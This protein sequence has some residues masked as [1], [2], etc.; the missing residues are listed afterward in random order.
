[1]KQMAE[2]GRATAWLLAIGVTLR[3][4]SGLVALYLDARI[5][6]YMVLA[7]DGCVALAVVQTVL[8][9]ADRRVRLGSSPKWFI[10]LTL[11]FLLG[12]LNP[13]VWGTRASLYGS[14]AILISALVLYA[15]S[16]T[17]FG[18]RPIRILF[19]TV[20]VNSMINALFALR[21][22][23]MGLSDRE[24]SRLIENGST[25]LVD[26]STRVPG[27]MASGQ[28]LAFVTAGTAA[29]ACMAALTAGRGRVRNWTWVLGGVSVAAAVVA[30]QRG[31]LLGLIAGICLGTFPA[32]SAMHWS[33]GRGARILLVSVTCAVLGW[34]VLQAV[35]PDRSA[36]LA[37]SMG[38]VG[39]LASDDSFRTRQAETIPIS[40][41]LAEDKW[42]GYG[43]GATGGPAQA[44]PMESP[45]R[46]YPLGGL[47][48]D[49]GYLFTWLQVGVF[50]AFSL[51]AFLWAARRGTQRRE[52]LSPIGAAF[53]GYLAVTLLFGSYLGLTSAVST[54]FLLWA[55]LEKV[56]DSDTMPRKQSIAD[57]P[58]QFAASRSLR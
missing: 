55:L 10:V 39:D 57:R 2:P 35:A 44:N 40:L 54:L 20:F 16:A 28:E 29:L 38:R 33:V 58:E 12:S 34:G 9:S 11:M 43:T 13:L 36:D 15:A 49:N 17:R 4:Q 18:R 56:V 31:P 30:L 23:L 3:L 51:L 53:G 22:A 1:M 37:S 7:A 26:E 14:R 25:F 8:S 48:A 27:I 52:G 24:L 46:A 45:L 50:G 42:T 6:D 5:P 41:K 21:Q 32:M 19:A 47:V